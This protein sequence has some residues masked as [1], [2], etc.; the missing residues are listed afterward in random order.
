MPEY[1]ALINWT[2]QSVR[3]DRRHGGLAVVPKEVVQPGGRGLVAERA[4][5]SAVVVVGDE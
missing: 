3:A 5:S 2:E 1:V 4:V